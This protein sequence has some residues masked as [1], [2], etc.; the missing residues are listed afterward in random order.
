MPRYKGFAFEKSLN[1]IFHALW[2]LLDMQQ[3]TIRPLS[4][5][6]AT[7]CLQAHGSRGNMSCLFALGVRPLNVI[8]LTY[9]AHYLSDQDRLAIPLYTILKPMILT[10]PAQKRGDLLAISLLSTTIVPKKCSFGRLLLPLGAPGIF[11]SAAGCSQGIK[12]S[13]H[14]LDCQATAGQH[15]WISSTATSTL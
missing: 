6:Q 4:T 2:H 11:S 10:L 7:A 1:T 14:C 5:G 12:R 9:C 3:D 13:Y 8:M 15:A